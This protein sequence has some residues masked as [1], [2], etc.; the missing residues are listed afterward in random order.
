M[1]L[2]NN[3]LTG[4]TP[5]GLGNLTKLNDLKLN[6]NPGLRGCIPVA[7]HRAGTQVSAVTCRGVRT[8]LRVVNLA[9][10]CEIG[11]GGGSS[12][13]NHSRHAGHAASVRGLRNEGPAGSSRHGATD[14]QP[15]SN[16]TQRPQGGGDQSGQQGCAPSP[17]ILINQTQQLPFATL[18]ADLLFD[19][20]ATGRQTRALSKASPRRGLS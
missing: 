14:A 20:C 8:E 6:G 15:A 1:V 19:L 2:G 3:S 4:S 17:V 10:T 13:L 12:P 7:L 16:Q 9:D 11:G 18:A 5:V